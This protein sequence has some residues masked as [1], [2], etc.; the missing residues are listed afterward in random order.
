MSR[1]LAEHAFLPAMGAEDFG[2][3]EQVLLLALRSLRAGG[4]EG[5]APH[6]AAK[7]PFSGPG[8]NLK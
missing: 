2:E 8:K 1:N 6:P 7:N 4:G 5:E 3:V